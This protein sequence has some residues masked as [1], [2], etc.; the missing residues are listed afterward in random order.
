MSTAGNRFDARARLV[1][2]AEL[3]CLANARIEIAYGVA[4]PL[5]RGQIRACSNP[6]AAIV[7]ASQ[8]LNIVR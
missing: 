8:R 7:L 6:T 5:N 3:F 1:A 2:C 4:L